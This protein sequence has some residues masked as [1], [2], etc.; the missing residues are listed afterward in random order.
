MWSSYFSFHFPFS[1]KVK[2]AEVGVGQKK[3][4]HLE[5][6]KG[7]EDRSAAL[8]GALGS[9]PPSWGSSA[10]LAPAPRG[11]RRRGF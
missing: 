9:A 5:P 1:H 8:G 3:H 2:S 4:T 10:L 6:W 7:G 11:W